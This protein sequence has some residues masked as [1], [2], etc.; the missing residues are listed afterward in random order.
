MAKSHR[1]WAKKVGIS[2]LRLLFFLLIAFAVVKNLEA[3]EETKKEI[4]K[5]PDH[6][7]QPPPPSVR[8]GESSGEAVKAGRRDSTATVNGR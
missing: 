7:S 1:D 8:E 3:W 4:E 2:G 5:I 6:P